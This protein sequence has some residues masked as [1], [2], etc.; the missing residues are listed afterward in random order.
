MII[1]NNTEL[2]L[3]FLHLNLRFNPFGELPLE[4]RAKLSVIDSAPFIAHLA[5]PRAV[6]QFLGEK[7]HGKTTHLLTLKEHLPTSG[8]VHFPE[9]TRP[10]IPH[11][12]PLMLDEAQRIPWWIRRRVFKGEKPLVLGTH[13]DFSSELTKWGREVWTVQAGLKTSQIQLDKIIR[14]RIEFARRHS[15]EVPVVT[16]NTIDKLFDKYGSDIRAIEW[17]L[18][19]LF[20]SLERPSNVEMRYLY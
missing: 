12:N 18:Y 20:Q 11:G 13:Q 2:T 6:L 17:H 8:Y 1:P 15:G 9:D 3:P 7:G 14:K 19:D 16:M 4:Y 10:P 5:K